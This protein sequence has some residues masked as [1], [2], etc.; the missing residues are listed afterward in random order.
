M[1]REIDVSNL[2]VRARENVSEFHP[3][4]FQMRN[5]PFILLRWE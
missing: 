1:L 3:K 4:F 5:Y 2:L